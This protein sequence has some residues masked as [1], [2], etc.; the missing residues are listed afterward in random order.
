M[1]NKRLLLSVLLCFALLFAWQYLAAYMGWVP[2]PVPE[3]Q[4]R[5]NAAPAAPTPAPLPPGQRFA[6]TAGREVRVDTPLY[7]AVFHSGGGI[8][9]SFLLKLYAAEQGPQAPRLNMISPEAS[10]ISPMGLLLNGQPTWNMGQWAFEGDDLSLEQGQSGTLV[11]SGEMHGVRITRSLT[12]HADT[13]LMDETV[14]LLAD[15]AFSPGRL[16]YTLAISSLGSASKYD[17]MSMAWS[18]GGSFSSEDDQKDLAAE[19]VMI[20]GDVTWAGM[21]SNYFLSAVV[22]SSGGSM[23]FK[24]RITE[25]GVWRAAVEEQDLA[26]APGAPAFTRVSWWM[27][28]KDDDLLK[29][30]PGGLDASIDMGWFSLLARFF[31]WLLRLF[32]SF[33]DNWGVDIILMTLLVKALLWPLSR[34]SYNSMEKMKKIQPMMAELQKKHA[35]NKEALSREMMQL[36]K[37]YG[38][39]P[40][41][42]CLPI[43]VQMPIFVALYQALLHSIELRHASF[44]TYLP[45]TDTLWLADLSAQDPFYITPL[46]MGAT[47]FLQQWL[48][49]AMGDPTQRRM[50]MLM[51][52]IFT[53]M[54]LTFP[55]GLVLYWLSNNI[56]SIAQQWWTLRKA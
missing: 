53:A 13:Y 7:S 55:A 36:Y 22:P 23:V 11:F 43:L 24:G 27:G 2:Q 17:A 29:A 47:M 37:T 3:T 48:A 33:V 45:F 42:G 12:F 39:N 35:G 32:H 18:L 8:L 41:S 9:Q 38:V 51:P 10:A 20:S 50:M 44:I 1:D 56:I 49:P 46:I 34:K 5:E 52:V 21:M 40:M 25:E 4:V 30:A 26:L 16:S 31:L 14:S 19:G 54:F 6:P 28:P 15:S